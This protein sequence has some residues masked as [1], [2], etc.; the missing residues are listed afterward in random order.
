MRYCFPPKNDYNITSMNCD[1]KLLRDLNA[2]R[3]I[4]DDIKELSEKSW[5][6]LEKGPAYQN[7][8]KNMKLYIGV[9]GIY[10]HV[11]VYP[12][13]FS[14]AQIQNFSYDYRYYNLKLFK[15]KDCSIYS[16]YRHFRKRGFNFELEHRE[17]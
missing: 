1:L 10:T 13:H 16:P 12:F 7:E 9:P 8:I 17:V 2:Y 14:N 3:D 4:F 5:L 11:P 6:L 15:I